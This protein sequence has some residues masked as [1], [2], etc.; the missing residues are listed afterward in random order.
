MLGP[1][2][3]L[4]FSSAKPPLNPLG[5]FARPRSPGWLAEIT[6]ASCDR[7]WE[8]LNEAPTCG[9]L[10]APLPVYHFPRKKVFPPLRPCPPSLPP[11]H[12]V[13][14]V[15]VSGKKDLYEYWKKDVA[16]CL[17]EDVQTRKGSA[18]SDAGGFLVV[19]VASQEVRSPGIGQAGF[20]FFVRVRGQ[21]WAAFHS[22]RCCVWCSSLGGY[23]RGG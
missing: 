18:K 11:F 13:N 12:Y 8:P 9:H 19:N 7:P 1:T 4:V 15:G 16:R 10:F 5:S 23:E 6:E 14:R 17:L 22:V 3:Q 2:F 20:I 21:V